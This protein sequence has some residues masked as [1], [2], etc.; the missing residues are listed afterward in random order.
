MMKRTRK[1][2]AMALGCGLLAG[3][4]SAALVVSN[5]ADNS[6]YDGGFSDGISAGTGCGAWTVVTATNALAFTG[7]S[8]ANGFAAG[9]GINTPGGDTGRAF[10]LSASDGDASSAVLP[11]NSAVQVGHTLR[12][13]MDYGFIENGGVIGARLQ[14]ASGEEVMAL[15]FTGGGGFDAVDAGGTTATG[16]DYSSDGFE[17][18]ITLDSASTY[19]A[20]ILRL[21]DGSVTDLSGT[22]ASP[23][24]GQSINQVAFTCDNVATSGSSGD[25][26]W[27]YYFN[28]IEVD[29]N[30]DTPTIVAADDADD[31]AY[32]GGFSTALNG[33]SGFGAWVLSTGT[34]AL[35]FTGDSRANGSTGGRGIN[36]P[37]GDLGTAWG[38]CA[39]DSEIAEAVRPLSTALAVGQTVSFEMDYSF[40]ENG[41]LVGAALRNASNE[42]LL[43]IEFLGG[44][45]GFYVS[46]GAGQTDTGLGWSQEG[47]LVEFTLDTASTYTAVVTSYRDG[48]VY[49]VSGSLASP[50][51]GQV[52]DNLAFFADNIAPSGS[53]SDAGWAYYFN[54]LEVTGAASGSAVSDWM[55]Y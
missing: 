33:G 44:G 30:T 12:F 3:S 7:N 40:V 14:N 15:T 41:G 43:S 26:G 32:D 5:S 6:A 53:A 20:S 10:G 37:G 35:A 27:F 48:A 17:V 36:T 18:E 49:T 52:I 28:S 25:Q 51:G 39:S 50:S 1:T 47:F 22:L 2:L 19:S 55:Q 54:S 4:A 9:M 24:G 31:A 29:D 13:G 34:N 23:A 21:N 16:I 45:S 8:R 38:I 42:K 11:F 46:D